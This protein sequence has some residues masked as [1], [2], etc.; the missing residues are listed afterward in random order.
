LC[1]LFICRRKF[2]DGEFFCWSFS[3]NTKDL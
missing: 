3:Q 1:F 2:S